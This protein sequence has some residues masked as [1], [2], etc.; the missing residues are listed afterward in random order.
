[1]KTMTNIFL[2]AIII[3]LFD[4]LYKLFQC[5]NKIVEDFCTQNVGV[6]MICLHFDRN[7]ILWKNYNIRLNIQRVLP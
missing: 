7:K 5:R 1:M 2:I 3:I 4:F 6:V